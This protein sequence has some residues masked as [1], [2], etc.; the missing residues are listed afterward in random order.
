MSLQDNSYFR[1]NFNELISKNKKYKLLI[2]SSNSNPENS[3]SFWK[4]DKENS[5]MKFYINNLYQK[6]NL[7][8]IP[9]RKINCF[10]YLNILFDRISL[11]NIFVVNKVSLHVIIFTLIFLISIIN[12]NF[13]EVIYEN[14]TR[15][16]RS[17]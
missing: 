3:V 15:N 17:K 10:Q 6:N 4:T 13:I 2:S 11:N 7:R 9:Y 1:L 16:N 5:R 12:I 8:F 14:I